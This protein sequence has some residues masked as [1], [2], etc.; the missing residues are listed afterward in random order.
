MASSSIDS[1]FFGGLA[2]HIAEQVYQRLASK[3]ASSNEPLAYSIDEAA[4]K[5]NLSRSTLKNMIREREIAVV[6][7]GTRVLITRRTI[8][9]WLERNET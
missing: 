9:D 3:I 8:E 2:E 4:A 5:L 7:R 6:R 1:Q